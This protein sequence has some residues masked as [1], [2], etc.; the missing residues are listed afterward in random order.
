[1]PDLVAQHGVGAEGVEVHVLA[2]PYQLRTREVVESQVV[3]EDLAHFDDI[4]ARGGLAGGADFAEEF[5][6]LFF[7]GGHGADGE[8]SLAERIAE[9]GGDLLAGVAQL[10]GFVFAGL[11]AFIGGGEK[12]GEEF[13]CDRE[14]ELGERYYDEDGEGDEAA[15]ILDCAL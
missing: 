12:I 4:L 5:L 15:E 9:E 13:E 14:E 1:M 8:A 10:G 3:F 7:F 6:K 11:L 2:H